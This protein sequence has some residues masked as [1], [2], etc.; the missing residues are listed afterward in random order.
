MT[1]MSQLFSAS[2]LQ[3][4]TYDQILELR[5]IVFLAMTSTNRTSKLQYYQEQ[6]QD[7]VDARKETQRR[8][9]IDRLQ[10]KGE[11]IPPDLQPGGGGPQ[12]LRLSFRRLNNVLT[13]GHSSDITPLTETSQG[14]SVLQK[15]LNEVS[16]ELQNS[17]ESA[18]YDKESFKKAIGPQNTSDMQDKLNEKERL[19]LEWAVSCERHFLE[20]YAPLRHARDVAHEYFYEKTRQRPRGPDS[21]Y[22]PFSSD[23]PLRRRSPGL[24]DS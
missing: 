7:Y 14:N 19:I 18:P 2:D 3:M 16:Q 12:P 13:L 15:R 23:H 8:R 1:V 11:A 4:L 21:L 6:A 20:F 10:A 5:D 22:S 9:Q 17:R 24:Y